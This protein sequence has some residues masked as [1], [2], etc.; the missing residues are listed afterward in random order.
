[1]TFPSS[2]S[3]V[4]TS[5]TLLSSPSVTLIYSLKAL[6]SKFLKAESSFSSF[7]LSSSSIFS[8]IT[9]LN[10]LSSIK[11]IIAALSTPSTN[12]LVTPFGSFKICF[13]LHIVP[14]E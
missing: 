12:T 2:S 4:I 7:K 11:S 8:T 1:M 14:M 10:F 13:I 6:D 9:S 5:M 3:L